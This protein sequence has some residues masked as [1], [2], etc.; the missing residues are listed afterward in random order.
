M[1]IITTITSALTSFVTSSASAIGTGVEG[2]LTVSGTNGRTLST[3]GI[4]IFTLFG[5]GL[6]VGL[7]HLIIGIFTR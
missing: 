4:V 2:L 1:D 6:A 5:M 3:A 7:M